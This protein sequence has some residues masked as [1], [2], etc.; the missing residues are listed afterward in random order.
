MSEKTIT[1]TVSGRTG[2]GKTTVANIINDALMEA[3]VPVALIDA[4]DCPERLDHSEQLQRATAI[5]DKGGV[6]DINTEK[7]I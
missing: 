7:E 2:S 5:R 3:G 4:P 6:V 1:V